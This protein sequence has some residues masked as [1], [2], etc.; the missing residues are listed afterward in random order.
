MMLK[1][2]KPA[3]AFCNGVCVTVENINVRSVDDNLVDAVTF[4]YTLATA[5]GVWAGEG[6]HS[7]TP[8]TYS[9]WDA[10]DRGAYEIVCAAIGLELVPGVLFKA[11][12]PPEVGAE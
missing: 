3:K 9:T 4:R 12:M 5:D 2:I 8:D 7:L 6:S 11:G 10:T 1:Q